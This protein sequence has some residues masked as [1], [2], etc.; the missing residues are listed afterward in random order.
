MWKHQRL[1]QV[2]YISGTEVPLRPVCVPIGV[3]SE[4]RTHPKPTGGSHVQKTPHCQ[5]LYV[6]RWRMR[7]MQKPQRLTE[8]PYSSGTGG[9]LSANRHRV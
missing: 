5:H 2:P 8:F 3:G 1:T 7:D 6:K 9:L 4:Y